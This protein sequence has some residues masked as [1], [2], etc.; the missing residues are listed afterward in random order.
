MGIK[1]I[2]V[3]DLKVKLGEGGRLIDVRSGGEYRGGHIV[4]AV[5]EP[6]DGIGGDDIKGRYGVSGDKPIYVTCAGGSRGMKA[7][8][9]L[10]AEGC[11]DVVCVTGGTRGWAE[12]GYEIVEVKAGRKVI[13]LERQVRIAAG[14]LVAVGTLVGV[15]GVPWAFVVP[16]FV[17]CGLVF[18][19]VTDTCGMGIMLSKMPWNK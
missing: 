9:K 13:S 14:G 8:E 3:E 16:G 1:T 6:L 17:G 5:N 19:G 15:L 4:G 10:V 7:C 2:S 12:A 11:G 18:A